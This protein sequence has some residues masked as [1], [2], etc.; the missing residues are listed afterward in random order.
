M[1]AGTNNN[2]CQIVS[3]GTSQCPF[4]FPINPSLTTV[5][6][7]INLTAQAS[8]VCDDAACTGGTASVSAGLP[9]TG[10][11]TFLGVIVVDENFVPLQG[12]IVTSA[13]GLKYPSKFASTTALASSQPVS[14]QGET[15]TFTATVA[16]VGRPYPTGKVIFKDLT[17]STTLG[18]AT[19]ISGAATL[20]TS[21]LSSGTHSIVGIYGG[22]PL[23]AG[24]KSA[25]L[26]QQ[27][28]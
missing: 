6:M 25:A 14:G 15:V 9:S 8:L 4:L 10:G 16:S 1:D 27:V 13:S 19:L 3:F 17:S 11:V 23:C 18:S 2:S 22:D 21:T 28:N 26:V 12:P 24:S 5:N 7:Y 20:T